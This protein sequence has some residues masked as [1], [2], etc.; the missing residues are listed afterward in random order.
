[1]NGSIYD[2]HAA[3][4]EAL[5]GGPRLRKELLSFAQGKTLEVGAGTGFNFRYYPNNLDVI[6]VEPD[7]GMRKKAVERA[8]HHPNLAKLIVG[9]SEAESLP[10]PDQTF[11]TVVATLAL[12]S[13]DDP[14]AAVNEAYRVLKPQGRFLLMEHIRKGSPFAGKVLD[15]LTPGWKRMSGGCHLNRSPAQWIEKSPFKVERHE[16]LWR[17]YGSSW[18]LRKN[19]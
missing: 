5:I 14:Q 18:V 19:G 15:W 16:I 13:V 11:D 9:D 17:G 10:Y 4:L 2:F 1:M 12:C 8:R 7:E 6:A 3:P